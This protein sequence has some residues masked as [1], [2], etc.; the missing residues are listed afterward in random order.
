MVNESRI[1]VSSPPPEGRIEDFLKFKRLECL[2]AGRQGLL[3][4]KKK[5]TNNIN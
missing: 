3:N 5:I 2:P 4:R 1:E